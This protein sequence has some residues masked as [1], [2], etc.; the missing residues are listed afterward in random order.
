MDIPFGYQ[1]YL[2]VR[3]F[4]NAPLWRTKPCSSVGS[5]PSH[6]E[7]P[8]LGPF[9]LLSEWCHSVNIVSLPSSLYHAVCLFLKHASLVLSVSSV[10]L[11]MDFTRGSIVI[12]EFAESWLTI[13]DRIGILRPPSLMGNA[14]S[15]GSA[16]L[17]ACIPNMAG[18]TLWQMTSST[19]F[20][21]MLKC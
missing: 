20:V 7:S 12:V 4:L 11:M 9:R 3:A 17:I 15:S 6:A 14:N 5:V 21:V 18:I 2:R 1:P 10:I 19:G 8:F 13:S 16:S